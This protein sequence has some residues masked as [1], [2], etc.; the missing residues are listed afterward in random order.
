ML[1]AGKAE[2]VAT[3]ARRRNPEVVI[4]VLDEDNREDDALDILN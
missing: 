4:K 2:R 1:E 3:E